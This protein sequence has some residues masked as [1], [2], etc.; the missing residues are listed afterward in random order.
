M[1]LIAVYVVPLVP[2]HG[3]VFPYLL[4]IIPYLEL[5]L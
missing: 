4:K 5:S 2:E 3:I 1:V